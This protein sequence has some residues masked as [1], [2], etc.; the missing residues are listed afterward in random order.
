MSR[1]FWDAALGL[2]LSHLC[3]AAALGAAG[4]AG[5]E[6]GK[7]AEMR[8][9]TALIAEAEE[10]R[11]PPPPGGGEGGVRAF[12]LLFTER[13]AHGE[14]LEVLWP[15]FEWARSAQSPPHAQSSYL[16]LRPFF[17]RD[18]APD[19]DALVLFPFYCRS[20]ERR[21]EGEL[22]SEHF[23]PVFGVERRSVDLAPATTYH[24]LWP[25]VSLRLGGGRWRFWLRP[26]L[27]LSSGFL[28]RGWW[29]FPVIKA[30]TGRGGWE[31]GNRFFYLLDPLFA[32]VRSSI[33]GG[34]SEGPEDARTEVKVL[35]GLL[36]YESSGG[37]WNL[38]MFWLRI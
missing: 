32:Y 38:R 22:T 8:G 26:A 31:G 15:V 24:T 20:L 23:W 28:D 17:R 21:E 35:G 6:R 34:R 33:A 19:R 1:N 18:R 7:L 5:P 3:L 9:R 2:R 10:A 14:T 16:R 25:I 27:D 13:A 37:R 12:P 29:L 4:C 11:Y 30:G 36:G